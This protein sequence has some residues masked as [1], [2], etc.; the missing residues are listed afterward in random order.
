MGGKVMSIDWDSFEREL[1]GIIAESADR[2]DEKLAGRISSITRMTDEEVQ[3]LFPEPADVKKLS[4][5]MR[6]VKS[7]EEKNTKI[8]NIVSNAEKF[9]PIILALLS[10]F[11]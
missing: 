7:A 4:E 9:G 6:I 5:L 1:D 2:T 11:A 3:E 10:K 8:N